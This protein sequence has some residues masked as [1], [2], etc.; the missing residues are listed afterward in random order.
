[1][2]VVRT[3]QAKA[4]AFES[5]AHHVLAGHETSSS[6]SIELEETYRKLGGLSLTQDE[7]F[8]QALRCLEERLYRAAHVMAWAGFIDLVTQ[9]MIEDHRDQLRRARPEWKFS[10]VEDLREN[11]AEYQLLDA[12]RD[13]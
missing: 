2:R 12:A 5:E 7:L 13:L 4:R 10:D 3:L 9:T 6:R 11:Y 1:M 8:R